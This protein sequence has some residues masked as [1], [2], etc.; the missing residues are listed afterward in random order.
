MPLLLPPALTDVF[1]EQPR[2]PRTAGRLR[3]IPGRECKALL[4]FVSSALGALLLTAGCLC[5]AQV[6]QHMKTK[7]ARISPE[8]YPFFRPKRNYNRMPRVLAL[9]AQ[10][11]SRQI[12]SMIEGKWGDV[13]EQAIAPRA[14]V[15]WDA[16]R[17]QPYQSR[18]RHPPPPRTFTNLFLFP[19]LPSCSPGAR[20]GL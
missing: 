4:S 5:R 11:Q 10:V 2:R 20:L 6:L 13:A 7:A 14:T 1:G 15:T 9:Q 19:P 18:R 3:G 8:R 12:Q 17:R 16:T